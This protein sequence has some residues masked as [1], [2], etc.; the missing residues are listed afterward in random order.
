M[1]VACACIR[2]R[3]MCAMCV[4]QSNATQALPYVCAYYA[5][6]R[7]FVHILDVYER[8]HTIIRTR[9]IALEMGW[10]FGHETTGVNLVTTR[11]MCVCVCCFV[12]HGLLTIRIG[13]GQRAAARPIE[14]IS[15]IHLK[16]IGLGS[17]FDPDRFQR[18]TGSAANLTADCLF[19]VSY[20]S[21][22]GQV[23]FFRYVLFSGFKLQLIGWTNN[24]INVCT[25]E[26]RLV[27]EVQNRLTLH[28]SFD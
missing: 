23:V 24:A 22:W 13:F 17:W 6:T 14:S 2:A 4:L 15:L 1:N 3:R 7:Q 26:L 20:I 18:R 25:H 27:G 12:A 5:S 8:T 9:M 21:V 10:E 11:L 28:I 16:I 19:C